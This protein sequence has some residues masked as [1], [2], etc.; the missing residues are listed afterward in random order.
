M[1]KQSRKRYGFGRARV[2]R[3]FLYMLQSGRCARCGGQ[4]LA[5]KVSIDHI[6]PWSIYKNGDIRNLCAMH[7][8]CNTRKGAMEIE[9]PFVVHVSMQ[10]W[11]GWLAKCWSNDP[12]RYWSHKEQENIFQH[13]N[14]R[15]WSRR[16]IAG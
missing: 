15:T 12:D 5:D 9:P 1:A 3:E 7:P 13:N 16:A 11:F 4:M 2:V 14:Y 6:K 8:R 10:D